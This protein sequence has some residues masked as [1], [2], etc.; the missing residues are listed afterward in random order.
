MGPGFESQRDHL[1][2]Q[3]T[4]G[5]FLFRKPGPSWQSIPLFG[6]GGSWVRIPAGSLKP[7]GNPG[8]S[9]F[10]KRSTAGRASRCFKR[11]GPGFS[12]KSSGQRD[13]KNASILQHFSL[14]S[15]GIKFGKAP[16]GLLSLKSS[17]QHLI[18]HQSERKCVDA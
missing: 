10:R 16:R 13:L 14:S 5:L 4:L 12:R 7:Q 15:L 9:L 17:K 18:H 2:L 6:A 3:K 8:L 1:K 11:E